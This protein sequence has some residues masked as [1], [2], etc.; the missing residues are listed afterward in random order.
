M[1]EHEK[2]L[3]RE[4]VQINRCEE[5]RAACAKQRDGKTW[6]LVTI[7]VVVGV[8]FVSSTVTASINLYTSLAKNE[9]QIQVLE[10]DSL[11]L[12]TVVRQMQQDVA[13]IKVDVKYLLKRIDSE[14]AAR[15]SAGDAIIIEGVPL[16]GLTSWLSEIDHGT[17]INA[18]AYLGPWEEAK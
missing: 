5:L 7:L 6:R 9:Q 13:E 16:M 1:S 11:D 14:A 17:H 18:P 8:A 15:A 2:E 3:D 12:K 4:L 10:R